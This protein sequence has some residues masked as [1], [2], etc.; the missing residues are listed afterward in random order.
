MKTRSQAGREQSSRPV[1]CAG[2]SSPSGSI[3]HQINVAT[4]GTQ[5]QVIAGIAVGSAGDENQPFSRNSR[6]AAVINLNNVNLGR[7][8]GVGFLF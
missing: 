8:I 4:H 1:A 6:Q 2:V 5:V 7:S 3:P